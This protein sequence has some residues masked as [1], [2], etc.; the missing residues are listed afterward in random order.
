MFKFKPYL[1]TVLWGGDNI[2]AFK[3]IRTDLR[4]IGESWEISAV[5]GLESRVSEGPDLDMTISELIDKYGSGLMGSRWHGERFPLL[6]KIIDSADNLSLQVHP[7]D[8]IARKRHDSKGKT[9]MW[10][11]V[12]AQPGSNILCGLKEKLDPQTYRRRVA[13]GTFI[14]AVAKYDSHPGDV[15]YL[16]AGRVHGIGPGNLIV[17]V[18]ETSDI[19]YRIYDYDRRDRDGNARELHTELA[20]EAIDYAVKA[21]YREPHNCMVDGVNTLVDTPVFAV[22]LIDTASGGRTLELPDS[23]MTLTCIEGEGTVTASGNDYPFHRGESLLIGARERA[24]RLSPSLRLIAA[25][26]PL[27]DRVKV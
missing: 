12:S 20:A 9:E 6:I 27:Q 5:E 19:T 16:P 25:Y 3:D 17:E 11:I 22:K 21:D 23:F 1:K 24:I 7:D 2:P 18:Q 26:L 15:F 10:Y 13:D 4:H 8:R 14:N